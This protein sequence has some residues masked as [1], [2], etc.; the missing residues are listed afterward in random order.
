MM[1]GSLNL[2]PYALPP[3]ETGEYQVTVSQETSIA[4]CKLADA[5]LDFAVE[6]EQISIAPGQVYSTYPPKGAVGTYVNCLAHLIL[7]RRTLPW[8]RTLPGAPRGIPW[9]ALLVFSEDEKVQVLDADY[10]QAATP[11]QGVYL[12]RINR[13]FGSDSELCRFIDIPRPL[14]E[15]VLP[16][17]SDLPY[18][19]HAR[20]IALDDKVTDS[21]VKSEWF[22]CVTANRYPRSSEEGEEAVKHSAHLVSL[23]GFADYIYAAD[24]KAHPLCTYSTVRMFSLTSWEFWCGR[25]DFDFNSLVS[26]LSADVLGPQVAMEHPTLQK[27]TAL[28]YCPLDHLFREGSR[29][30]SWY[31]PP[32]LPQPPWEDAVSFCHYADRLLRYD[33]ELGMMDITYSA[34][35]QLGRLLAL[36]KTPFAQQLMGWRLQN[37]QKAAKQQNIRTLSAALNVQSRAP[38]APAPDMENTCRDLWHDLT[39]ALADTCG[40]S[41]PAGLEGALLPRFQR[42]SPPP[43]RLPTNRPSL[44]QGELLGL[45]ETE[46]EE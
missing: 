16:D 6:A 44:T 38:A 34:A 37:K 9:V 2:A 18:L 29:S 24:R 39:Q 33:P 27:L 13:R 36:Q 21:Q 8:E 26:Q 1:K 15:D 22:S 10:K 32:L 43:G 19:A 42:H 46:T 12:P 11:T 7:H 5:V 3:L 28:G 41:D 23:E 17:K 40:H 25:A 4:N 30:V 20:K 31:R 45:F 35:W 14:F